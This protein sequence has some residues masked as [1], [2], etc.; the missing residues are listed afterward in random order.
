MPP[1]EDLKLGGSWDRLSGFATRYLGE[2]PVG[3]ISFDE[4][5]R[6]TIDTQVLEDLLKRKAA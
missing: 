3:A 6:S 2:V 4:T 5:R 1:P